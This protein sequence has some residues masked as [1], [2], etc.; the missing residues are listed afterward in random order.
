MTTRPTMPRQSTPS[1][2]ALYSVADAILWQNH[3]LNEL[4]VFSLLP[5]LP[6]LIVRGKPMS[7]LGLG[8]LDLDQ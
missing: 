5:E 8:L 1:A 7:W 3:L 4:L 2:P 6:C